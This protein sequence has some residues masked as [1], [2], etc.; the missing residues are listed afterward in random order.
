MSTVPSSRFDGGHVSF[1]IDCPIV[2]PVVRALLAIDTDEGE[3]EAYLEE[4]DV[5]GKAAGTRDIEEL[6]VFEIGARL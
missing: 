1:A 4:R 3:W 5:V 6:H 2:A